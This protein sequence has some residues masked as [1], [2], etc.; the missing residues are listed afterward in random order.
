MI[1]EGASRN[2]YLVFIQVFLLISL[3]FVISI[4]LKDSYVGVASATGLEEAISAATQKFGPNTYVTETG[5]GTYHVVASGGQEYYYGGGEFFSASSP[6]TLTN[7]SGF[8]FKEL[9][10]RLA[11]GQ[12]SFGLGTKSVGGVVGTSEVYGALFQGLFWGAVLYGAAKLVGS[13]LG[14]NKD[15]TDAVANSV[16]VG[17]VGGGIVKAA[18][19]KFGPGGNAYWGQ[20]SAGQWGFVSGVGIAVVV[21]LILYKDTKTKTVTF[22][23]LPWEPALGGNACEQC[24]KDSLKP[25]SEY[26]CKSLGQACDLVNKGSVEEKC[27]WISP[28]D[29][30]SPTITPDV[31]VL[32]PVNENLQYKP[33]VSRPTAI[34][35]RIVKGENGCLQAFTPLQFGFTTNE[36]A[37]CKVDYEAK[38]YEE[39]QFFIGENNYYILNHTQRMRL[40]SPITSNGSAAPLFQND[41]TFSLYVQCQDANGNKNDDHYVVEFCVDKSPDTTSPSIEGTSINSGSAVRFEV[42]EAPIEVYVNEPGQCKWSLNDRIFDDMEHSFSCSTDP[43]EINANLA[44][45]CSGNLTGIRDRENNEFYFRCR[46]LEGN[47]NVESYKFSL[48]GSQQLSVLSTEPNGTIFGSTNTVKV[49]LALTTDDGADEGKA[50]C[51]YNSSLTGGF[52]QMFTTDDF[53]HRQIQ[54]LP[55]GNYNYN[56]RCIDSG[57]NAAETNTKF[58]V[59][60]DKEAPRVVRTYK[61]QAL[62]IITNEDA[63]CSYSLQSCN[64]NIDEG[65]KL[66]YSN[67]E[68]K[69]QLFAPWKSGVKYHVKCIDKYGNQPSPNEC[70]VIISPRGTVET[71]D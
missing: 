2:Y 58:S 43:G 5:A 48:R 63:T 37:Q 4:A 20:L 45:T 71:S 56:F 68:V 61:D 7:P 17:A 15:T 69:N 25:C 14:L 60:V 54:E 19:L 30:N 1:K 13:M 40:P 8:S 50:I 32:K 62:K 34:G 67:A 10:G 33:L 6:S 53:S 3:S 41:G 44:Y 46:D 11:T 16:L 66:E 12:E 38:T 57:G 42:D 9:T 23:C 70:S 59:F 51:F 26:R 65:I 21:F 35:T 24:N 18:L 36:P 39:M 22:Q 64:F 52:V 29:V 55:A 49:E 27:V 47:T 28:K 31:N